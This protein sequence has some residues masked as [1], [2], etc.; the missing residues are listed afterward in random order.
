MKHRPVLAALLAVLA[1]AVVGAQASS[2]SG[3]HGRQHGQKNVVFVQTNELTGNQIAVYDRGFDGRLNRVATYPTG[4]NGER[5]LPA[6]NLTAWPR[7]AR[8]CTTVG[9]GSCSRSTPEATPCRPSA[10]TATGSA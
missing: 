1:L 5:P 10:C 3:G 4:G 6:P 2:A 9:T 7:R 8:L